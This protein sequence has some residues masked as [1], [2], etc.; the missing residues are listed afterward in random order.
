MLW[1]QDA[2]DS[3]LV[4]GDSVSGLVRV[5]VGAIGVDLGG[6]SEDWHLLATGQLI[7][8]DNREQGEGKD[9]KLHILREKGRRI[10]LILEF[11]VAFQFTVSWVGNP[12]GWCLCFT[13]LTRITIC[14][15]RKSSSRSSWMRRSPQRIKFQY[16][17]VT[18]HSEFH[19]DWIAEFVVL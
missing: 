14:W 13:L 18:T 1:V 11:R 17:L 10:E 9:L 16:F 8:G 3:L 7:G 19:F 15:V 2:L 5:L 12:S 4:G 6:L